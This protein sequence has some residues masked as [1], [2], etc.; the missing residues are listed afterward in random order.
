LSGDKVDVIRRLKAKPAES[1]GTSVT[2]ETLVKT[3]QH[4]V[5]NND[6]WESWNKP[7]GVVAKNSCSRSNII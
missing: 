4:K 2:V 7:C 3:C 1:K 6:E 5:K